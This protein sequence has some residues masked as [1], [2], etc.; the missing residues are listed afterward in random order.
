[1][2][3]YPLCIYLGYG[4]WDKGYDDYGNDGGKGDEK[5]GYDDKG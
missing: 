5:G 4:G 3:I 2:C 1:M